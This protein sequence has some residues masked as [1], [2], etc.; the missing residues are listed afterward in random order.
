MTFPRKT[1]LTTPNYD[2]KGA[3]VPMG[4]YTVH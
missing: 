2:K 4:D 1:G 3:P